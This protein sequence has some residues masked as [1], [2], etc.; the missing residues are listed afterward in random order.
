[1]IF[2]FGGKYQGKLNFAKTLLEEKFK[3]KLANKNIKIYN[4]EEED[5]N[6]IAQI[7]F[8][9][10]EY[11]IFYNVQKN[12]ELASK[13]LEDLKKISEEKNLN[14]KSDKNL[15][16]KI[17]EDKIFIGDDIS[18]GIVPLEESERNWRDEVG[19][20]YQKFSREAEEVYRVWRGISQKL[21]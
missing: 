12:P 9:L 4:F 10:E 20:L 16:E 3:I 15:E 5:Q 2:I 14:K 1:M 8:I 17:C 18:C 21:K 19:R 6:K 13:I 7:K 11:Q